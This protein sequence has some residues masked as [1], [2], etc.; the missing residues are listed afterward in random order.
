[1]PPV[2]LYE[3]LVGWGMVAGL[4]LIALWLLFGGKARRDVTCESVEMAIRPEWRDRGRYRERERLNL[5]R[6]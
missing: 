4:M 1:M 5:G 6:R 3:V 2:T